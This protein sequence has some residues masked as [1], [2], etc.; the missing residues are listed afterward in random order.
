MMDPPPA[1][2]TPQDD[3]FGA[4]RGYQPIE[5]GHLGMPTS[6]NNTQDQW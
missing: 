1:L 6:A 3:P 2:P 5:L 4:M